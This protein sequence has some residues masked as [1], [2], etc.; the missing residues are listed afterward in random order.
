M[1]GGLASSRPVDARSGAGAGVR[2][3]TLDVLRHLFAVAVIFQHMPSKTR[4]SPELN[5]TIGE[6]VS[7]VDGAVLGFF[8]ISGLLSSS[9][10]GNASF[11]ASAR[12]QAWRLLLP[13]TLFSLLYGVLLTALGKSSLED[14]LWR[15]LTLQ[16]SGPQLYFLPY[17]LAV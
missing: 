11:F 2:I 15:L 5:R 8:L 1:A 16:G 9:G 12:R 14:G 6:L 10:S 3:G 13:F 17:L 4:Y 7:Y